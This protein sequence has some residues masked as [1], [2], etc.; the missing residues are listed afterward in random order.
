MSRMP[1]LVVTKQRRTKGIWTRYTYPTNKATY[2]QTM[3]LTLLFPSA[4]LTWRILQRHTARYHKLWWI[5]LNLRRLLLCLPVLSLL[6]VIVLNGW[7]CRY[8]SYSTVHACSCSIFTATL[9]SHLM[10]TCLSSVVTL[11]YSQHPCTRPSSIPCTT[12]GSDRESNI[13]VEP[14]DIPDLRNLKSQILSTSGLD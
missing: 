8:P 1:I 5:Q 3:Q 9:P 14:H 10:N 12:S 2:P 11:S 7:T 6:R 13:H 4:S